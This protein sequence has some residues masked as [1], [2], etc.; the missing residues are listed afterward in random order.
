MV[1]K[2]VLLIYKTITH[3]YNTVNVSENGFPNVKSVRR[4]FRS[5]AQLLTSPGG[6]AYAAQPA[7]SAEHVLRAQALHASVYLDRRYISA[8]DIGD[9]N[10]MHGEADP[11]QFHSNYFVVLS[12]DDDKH[13]VATARQIFAQRTAR[14]SSFPTMANLKIYPTLKAAIEQ[15]NPSNCVE[16][17]GLAKAKGVESRAVLLLYRS[18][19]QYSLRHGHKVWLMAC[20]VNVYNRL[21]FMFG[22]ALVRIGQDTMYMGSM[23]VP[24]ML[25]VDRSIAPLLNE[26]RTLNLAKR[27]MKRRLVG[28]MMSG[29]P[30][31]YRKIKRQPVSAFVELSKQAEIKNA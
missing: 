22:D 18:M 3:C 4:A 25:E 16:I 5:Y 11:H 24:A 8:A 28:F 15:V 9:D 20:D 10:R 19:W 14:H 30:E 1:L 26:S 12:V 29:L 31:S 17:S 27:L 6:D 7:S 13:V 21:K 2:V 23:V